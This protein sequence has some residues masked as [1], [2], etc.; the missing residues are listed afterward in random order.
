MRKIYAPSYTLKIVQRW[1][2]ENI[3]YKLH[4]S[5]YCFGYVKGMKCPLVKNAEVHKYNLFIFKMDLKDFFPSISS[6]RVMA[7]FRSIGYNEEVSAHLTNICTCDNGL[8][9]GAVTSPYLSNLICA[10][11]DIR[12]QKYCSKR[13]IA[14]SRYADD[15]TFSG[16]NRDTLKNIYSMVVKIIEDEG[17]KVNISKTKFITPKSRKSVTGITIANE[18]L[19]APRQLKKSVRS[20]IHKAIVTCDY[21]EIDKI[22]G[23]IAYISSIEEGYK[24][25]IIEYINKFYDDKATIFNE[26]VLAFN[27]NKFFKELPDMQL[28]KTSDFVSIE[29][30]EQFEQYAY[31]ERHDFLVKYGYAK[32]IE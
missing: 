3:L 2:L 14:F 20:M 31:E 8:P 16:N 18:Q 24:N 28:K 7:L 13:D 26:V 29:D 21:N 19:K 10:K 23:N 5:E 9:Q 17:Y 30:T 1:I 12:L 11:L 32:D 6:K 15:L 27:A 22:R 25:K 4:V